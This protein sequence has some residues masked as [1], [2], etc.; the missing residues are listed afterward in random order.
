MAA[1]FFLSLEN[2][3]TDQ[4]WVPLPGRDLRDLYITIVSGGGIGTL[5]V[6][7]CGGRHTGDSTWR[8]MVTLTQDLGASGLN[9]FAVALEGEGNLPPVSAVLFSTSGV[10][11][12]P[13]VLHIYGRPDVG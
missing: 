7:P 10:T 6:K 5:T 3:V 12:A 4:V 2:N 8:P 9:G 1:P 13:L 11:N